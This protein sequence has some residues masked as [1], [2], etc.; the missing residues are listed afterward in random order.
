MWH[1]SQKTYSSGGDATCIMHSIAQ[2]LDKNSQYYDADLTIENAKGLFADLVIASIATTSNFSYALP[3][4]LLHNKNVLQR[5]QQEVDQVIGA[6]RQPSIFDRDQMPYSVATVYEL[7]R[8][9]SLVVAFPHA[10]LEDATLGGY[11]IPAGTITVP[12][13]IAVLHDKK[14]WGDPEVFRPERFLDEDGNLLPADHPTRKH[15]L[16]FGA[17]TRVCVGEAFA[18]KRLF[19]LLISI[20]QSFDLCNGANALIPCDIT[21]YKDGSILH[22][23]RYTVRLPQRQKCTKA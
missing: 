10:A 5:V 16:Q 20:T 8:Y 6:E 7:L 9:A 3:N 23:Q 17:G 15:M 1:E 12:L 4:I 14:L 2:L 22:H 11:A 21:S 13:F 19:I 18:L